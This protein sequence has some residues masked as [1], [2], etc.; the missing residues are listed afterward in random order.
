MHEEALIGTSPSI[1]KFDVG[2]ILGD[3]VDLR[4]GVLRVACMMFMQ[5]FKDKLGISL[6]ILDKS[7]TEISLER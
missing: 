1:I 7:L 2:Q 6:M 5:Q 3:P 4:S